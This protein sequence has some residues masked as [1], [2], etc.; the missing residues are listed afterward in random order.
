[1][2]AWIWI[3]RSREFFPIAK[4]SNID[5]FLSIANVCTYFICESERFKKIG[6]RLI[7][8]LETLQFGLSFNIIRHVFFCFGQK[9]FFVGFMNF[10]KMLVLRKKNR[11]ITLLAI[12]NA[13]FQRW[14]FTFFEGYLVI[15]WFLFLRIFVNIRFFKNFFLSD[16]WPS[17]RSS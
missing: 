5:V 17:K 12:N 11:K 3:H 8:I 10:W 4:L 14:L 16:L 1:M 6:R 13:F 15:L 2:R 9:K 7:K